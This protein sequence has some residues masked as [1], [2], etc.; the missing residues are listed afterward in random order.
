M[1]ISMTHDIKLALP[2]LLAKNWL[3]KHVKKTISETFSLT[4]F[5]QHFHD[6][7]KHGGHGVVLFLSVLTA[8]Q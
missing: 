8:Q 5:F 2:F 1:Q 4:L 7:G 3:N 6:T